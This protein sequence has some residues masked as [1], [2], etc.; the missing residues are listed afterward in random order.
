MWGCVV[1]CRGAV[2][3]PSRGYSLCHC[4]SVS[5]QPLVSFDEFI[6]RGVLRRVSVRK[7]SCV[8]LDACGPCDI[9]MNG[10]FDSGVEKKEQRMLQNQ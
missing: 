5:S 7:S 2:L 9:G 1:W 8:C 4:S 3:A 6:R 10:S